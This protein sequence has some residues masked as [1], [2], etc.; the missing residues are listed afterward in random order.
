M[1]LHTSELGYSV[2]LQEM[3]DSSLFS[4]EAIAMMRWQASL[5]ARDGGLEWILMV[6]NDVQL[7]KD[8]LVRLLAHDRPIVFPFLEDLSRRWPRVVAPLSG[9]NIEESG[10]GLL[11][12]RWA[13]M[14]CMLINTK[15]FNVLE[16]TCWRGDDYIFAQALNHI[17]HRIYLDTD[18]VV[19]VTHG[20]TRHASKDY[21]EFWADHEAMRDRLRF[22]YRDRRAPPGFNP[23]TDNGMM[24]D[25]TYIAVPA[26]VARPQANGTGD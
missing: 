25:K 4:F 3:M 24:A 9:P 1:L 19:N 7:E 11:P 10:Q 14:S 22:E 17:G 18:T 8:T 2:S 5:M 6:D 21:K 20:P 15:I 16:P 23:E 12:V 13:A 26:N